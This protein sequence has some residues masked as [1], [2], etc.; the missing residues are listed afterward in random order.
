MKKVLLYIWQLPQN[1]LGL[2]LLLFWKQTD[3][4]A[5]KDKTVHVCKNFPGGVSLGETII[6]KRYPFNTEA[7]KDVKHEYGHSIQSLYL[8]WF[9]LL[10]IGLPSVLFNV[11][12]RLFHHPKSNAESMIYYY[13]YYNLPWERWA[14]KLG[15]VQR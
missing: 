6:V 10:V 9:Y 4:F 5:Y 7:W 2:I 8:G 14:D 11:Y 13:W 15:N 1:L 3:V 12:D